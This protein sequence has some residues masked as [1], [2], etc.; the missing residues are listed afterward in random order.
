MNTDTVEGDASGQQ[1]FESK[2][3]GNTCNTSGIPGVGTMPDG[4]TFSGD[5][6]LY[7][8]KWTRGFVVPAY[9]SGPKG[10]GLGIITWKPGQTSVTPRPGI[11][12]TSMFAHWP[13]IA[14]D[15]AG[16]IYLVWDLDKRKAGTKGGCNG[17]ETPAPNAIKMIYTKD[18]GKT[19]SAPMTVAAPGNARVFWPWI[20]AGDAGKVS[21]VWYQTGPNQLADNDCQAAD[22]YVYESTILNATT[23]SPTRYLVNAVGRSVHSGLVCQGGT[24]CVATGQDRRLGDYFTNALDTKG[25]V[26]IATGDTKLLDPTTGA[27][28]PT[29]RPLFVRQNRGPA[30]YGTNSCS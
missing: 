14:I 11:M 29:S 1:I 20:A 28:Y 2:D 9:F 7:Y 15:K 16:T 3:G 22:I 17:A 8:Y 19:W 26:F 30:L 13:A 5:G 23:T 27:P 24:T 4:T 25:C 18:L 12:G 10:F 21:V 6:K